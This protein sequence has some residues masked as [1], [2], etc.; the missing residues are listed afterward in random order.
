VKAYSW[1]RAA[2]RL[3]KDVVTAAHPKRINE[4]VQ[5][6]HEQRDRPEVSTPI[7]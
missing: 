7:G 3:A 2:P 6:A 4:I 5:L 1:A